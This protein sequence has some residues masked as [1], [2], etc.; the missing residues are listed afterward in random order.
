MTK[1]VRTEAPAMEKDWEAE[2][3][4]DAL[5]KSEEVKRKPTLY[6]KA[7]AV[8]EKRQKDAENVLELSPGMQT[9]LKRRHQLKE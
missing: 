4:A 9:R 7:L 3:A 2:S 5:L 8:L 1:T 6:K